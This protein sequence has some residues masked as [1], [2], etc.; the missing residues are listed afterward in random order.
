VPGDRGL[1]D[2]RADLKGLVGGKLVLQTDPEASS[3]WDWTVWT[4]IKIE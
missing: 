3:D 1:Q 4:A 2:F